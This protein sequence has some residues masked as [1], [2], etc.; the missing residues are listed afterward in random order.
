M[1]VANL[2]A[3][4]LTK[5]IKKQWKE[6]SQAEQTNLRYQFVMEKTK[7]AQGDF[8]KTQGTFANQLR[9]AQLN[10]Q[11]LG[12]KLGEFVLPYIN[13]GVKAFNDFIGAI[14]NSKTPMG[15]FVQSATEVLIP[16]MGQLKDFIMN[17]VIPRFVA[18]GTKMSELYST[19]APELKGAFERL[20]DAAS[21][22]TTGGLDLVKSGFQ[23]V[24]DN[25][26]L[27]VGGIQ[28]IIGIYAIYQAA[29]VVVAIAQGVQTLATWLAVAADAALTLGIIALYVK[30]F[31]LAGATAVVTAAQW[32]LNAAFW[33][34]PITWVVALIIILVG[35]FIL[36]YNKSDKF[37]AGVQKLW[38]GIKAGSEWAINSAVDKINWFIGKI[39]DL[40]GLINKI[41][42]VEIGEVGT[43]GHVDFTGKEAK[44]KKGTSLPSLPSLKGGGGGGADKRNLQSIMFKKNANGT[45][46]FSGGAG[47]AGLS[48]V[49]ERGGEMQVLKN[50][51]SVLPADRT[52]E[53]IQGQ[54]GAGNKNVTINIDAKGMNVA[55]L[56]T[57]LETRI[58][59]I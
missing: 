54:S 39:N 29:C 3:F 11:T 47:G 49:N 53:M 33:A 31:I 23:W 46:Y 22:L 5:G 6:M 56:V 43:L 44:L 19:Y 10:L 9:I 2:Q 24:I 48:M 17:E 12:A 57:Q 7:D 40:I 32:L 51:T 15:G 28:A 13:K 38:E 42:G 45:K 1:S 14:Q 25:K 59:N 20:K 34:C 16:A 8:A 27:V 4:A 41:P 58:Q 21:T 26:G 50:G 18:I 35:A 55:E 36:A 37:R 52:K 30:D